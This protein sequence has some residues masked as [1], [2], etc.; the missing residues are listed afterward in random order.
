[1][2][3]DSESVIQLHHLFWGEVP[4]LEGRKELT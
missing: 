3:G 1:V 4:P 2:C